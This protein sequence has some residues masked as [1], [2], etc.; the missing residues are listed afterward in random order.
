M[1][2]FSKILASDFEHF[3]KSSPFLKNP[4]PMPNKRLLL[5]TNSGLGS[6]VPHRFHLAVS[7]R[8]RD[9]KNMFAWP[10]TSINMTQCME[11]SKDEDLPDM[12]SVKSGDNIPEWVIN[13]NTM[14]KFDRACTRPNCWFMH[15]KNM[16]PTF[17]KADVSKL[18]DAS[19]YAVNL[20][21]C[22]TK[23]DRIRLANDLRA[24]GQTFGTVSRCLVHESKQGPKGN[25]SANI[26][27]TRAD[28]ALKFK[29][30]LDKKEIKGC[31]AEA[32]WNGITEYTPPKVSNPKVSYAK[33]TSC[34]TSATKTLPPKKVVEVDDDGFRMQGK[35]G[36]TKKT[37]TLEDQSEK[38]EKIPI[39]PF[40]ALPLVV[41]QEEDT[42]DVEEKD[43][44]DDLLLKD[45]I[46]KKPL[47]HSGHE[48]K[49]NFLQTPTSTQS[50]ATRLFSSPDCVMQSSL[51]DDQELRIAPDGKTY[52]KS[53]FFDYFDSLHQ[54]NKAPK[55]IPQ[56]PPKDHEQATSKVED[57]FALDSDAESDDEVDLFSDI[58]DNDIDEEEMSMWML[59]NAQLLVRH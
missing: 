56:S 39:N 51:D 48:P 26:H 37:P 22:A 18:V 24:M 13:A 55:I 31:V 59:K 12:P 41:Q 21:S 10:S 14:C 34:T 25:T 54:W 15:T 52:T 44:D 11:T 33:V 32:R 53:E 8:N 49:Q 3:E 1:S 6:S 23:D 58:D 9:K 29:A 57:R 7:R 45:N 43:E 4:V 36:K 47:K 20:P 30:F 5:V 19:I 28:P 16:S 2:S 50:W 27:F 42:N 38:K 35:R 40:P 17:E 46:T